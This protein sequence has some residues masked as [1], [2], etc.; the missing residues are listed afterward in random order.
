MEQA[1]NNIRKDFTPMEKVEIARRIEEAMG[2]RQGQRTDLGKHLPK[3]DSEPKGKSTDIA[4]QAV[5]W[6]GEQYRQAKKVA[7]RVGFEGQRRRQDT[8][9]PVLSRSVSLTVPTTAID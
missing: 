8:A 6:S 1:E 3:C 5:G 4:A 2:N 9:G 7:R